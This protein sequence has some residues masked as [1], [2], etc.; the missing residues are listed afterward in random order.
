MTEEDKSN[1]NVV[2]SDEDISII[3]INNSYTFKIKTTSVLYEVDK[4]DVVRREELIYLFYLSDGK[5]SYDVYDLDGKIVEK[6]VEISSS[7]VN[8]FGLVDA[9]NDIILY[10]NSSTGSYSSCYLYSAINGNKKCLSNNKNEVIIDLKCNQNNIY[11]LLEKDGITEGMFGNG[12]L[13][14]A[15]VIAKFD[16]DLKLINYIVFDY[17]ENDIEKKIEL[18][19]QYIYLINEESIHI[20]SLELE[21]INH[22]NIGNNLLTIVSDKSLIYVFYYEKVDVF[23]DISLHE[24]ASIDYELEVSQVELKNNAVIL[25]NNNKKYKVDVV[26]TRNLH[27]YKYLTA[28]N[29]NDYESSI[30]NL[31]SIFGAV[32]F[33]KKEY[34]DYYTP[35]FFG[36]YNVDL[37]YKTKGDIGF[38]INV[39]ENIPLECNIKDN[40]IYPSG[41]RIIFNG[42]GM[43][44]GN[45]VLSNYQVKEEGRHELL[46]TGNNNN[47]KIIFFVNHNQ[48]NLTSE[49]H[50]VI[51]DYKEL[52]K[53]ES[54]TISYNLNKNLDIK[55]IRVEGL[56]IEKYE[57]KDNT[58]TIYFSG[59]R[60]PGF[61]YVYLDYFDYDEHINDNLIITNRY[62]LHDEYWYHIAKKEPVISNADFLEDMSF[63][64]DLIDEDDSVR[65]IE[66][67][68]VNASVNYLF[69][70]PIGNSVVK[71]SDVPNGDYELVVSIVYDIDKDS[72]LKTKLY[73]YGVRIN[74]NN[75]YGE[76]RI[77]KD[78]SRYTKVRVIIDEDFLKE[79]VNEIT[80]NKEVLYSHSEI[81]K[82][83][84]IIYSII[85][86]I[87]ALALGLAI[88]YIFNKL[89]NA[90]SNDIFR[91]DD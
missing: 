52:G 64:F 47:K 91:D 71:F 25:K 33:S 70:S 23:T 40:V 81:S 1:D 10:Y 53:N 21:S 89:K 66:F 61:Y 54:F 69:N 58:I 49:S 77:S 8:D 84:N 48:S 19:D 39:I 26:D 15:I 27:Q 16:Y 68:L 7:N 60:N 29:N 59:S 42:D 41:Y 3:K 87:G 12:G 55:N 83:N 28:E 73:S 5:L 86:F 80:Y 11:V 34:N 36:I 75:T 79:S 2:F 6:S 14:Q 44:D 43:L 88:K 45:Q 67:E 62:Y 38:K 85:G 82:N 22:K 65:Q 24:I 46:I 76:V 63:S 35:G 17:N 74:D 50:M 31:Y 51:D 4:I 57:I 18:T 32:S 72:Y 20:F 56:E 78:N 37:C 9:F 90:N 30:N 13:E